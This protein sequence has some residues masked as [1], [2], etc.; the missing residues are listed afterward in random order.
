M[1]SDGERCRVAYAH[2][3]CVKCLVEKFCY[4]CLPFPYRMLL[5]LIQI[6][7]SP[8]FPS[9]PFAENIPEMCEI[10]IAH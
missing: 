5:I 4:F 7:R 3:V 6:S 8:S 2:I 1:L 9:L 10:L